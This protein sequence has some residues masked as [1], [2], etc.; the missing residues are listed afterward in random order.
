MDAND[1]VIIDDLSINANFHY[2][3]PSYAN[4]APTAVNDMF[5]PAT[6]ST[7]ATG[8]V[9]PN[10]TDPDAGEAVT[11]AVLVTPPLAAEG[12]LVFNTNGSFSFTPAVGFIGRN[13]NLYL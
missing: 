7:V 9:I 10:D 2:P 4:T 8:N 13:C 6:L 12:T 3:G 11:S 1:Q 5:F